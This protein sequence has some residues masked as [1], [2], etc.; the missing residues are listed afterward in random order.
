MQVE[1]QDESRCKNEMK[2][3]GKNQTKQV[4][5]DQ[6]KNQQSRRSLKSRDEGCRKMLRSTTRPTEQ[7]HQKYTE[8]QKSTEVHQSTELRRQST[9]DLSLSRRR[10]NDLQKW[11]MTVSK[12]HPTDK[13]T[14]HREAVYRDIH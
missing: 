11:G 3:S 13:P 10:S 4:D 14:A 6:A 2:A 12:M 8:V 5:Q 7:D 9:T 1:K